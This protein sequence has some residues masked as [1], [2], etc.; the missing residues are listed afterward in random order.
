MKRGLSIAVISAMLS[1]LSCSKE[2]ISGN[3]STITETR[4]ISNFTAISASGSTNV[5]IN[6]GAAFRVEVKGYSNLL[7]YYETRLVNNSLQVGYKQNENVKNDNV[8]VFITLPVL[9]VLALS[10]SGSIT[11]TGAFDGN[12]DFNVT[13]S[14]SGNIHFSTGTAQNFYSKVDG[15]GS[16]YMLNMVTDKADATI[17]GS[18]KTEINASNQLKVKIIGSGKLYYRGIPIITTS[19][20]GSGTVLPK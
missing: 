10:G 18:G 6:Q 3:G 20:T 5:Y 17:I 19:I 4:N 9:N 13:V 11:T 12:I 8:E 1:L 7:P 16:I 2:R 15:S 14:G